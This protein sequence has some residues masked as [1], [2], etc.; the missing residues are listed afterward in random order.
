[1][2][3]E[4]TCEARYDKKTSVGKAHLEATEL[5][6]RGTFQLRIALSDV[7]AAEARKGELR[8]EWP[9]GAVTL[10]LGR[11]AEKWALKIRYPRGRLDKLGIKAGARV[12]VIAVDDAALPAEIESRTKDVSY[13][14]AKED[15]D[16][17][18]VGMTK[19]A[20]LS[21]LQVLRRSIKRNGAIWA[22][23]PKGRKEL[24]ED[25]V[26]AYG[27]K[28]GLVDVKVVSFSD[29]LSGLKMVIP[30]KDR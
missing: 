10:A 15:T 16:V 23:W 12:A 9:E 14:R 21:R 8:V 24:R 11:D 7:R 5:R 13:E 29:T 4:A 28:A 27:A 26:R 6:F 2:G 25:D 20:D 18:L 1:M 3:L 19:I 30:V 17:A 22:I